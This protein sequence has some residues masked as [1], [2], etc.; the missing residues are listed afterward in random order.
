MPA[1]HGFGRDDYERL[2]PLRPKAFRN[3][4][5]QAINTPLWKLL[6]SRQI[7]YLWQPH[8]ELEEEIVASY[9]LIRN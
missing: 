1:D 5:Q 2:L 6:K 9:L 4:P 7:H 8:H 3:D